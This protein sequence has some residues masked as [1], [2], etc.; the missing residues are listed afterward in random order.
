MEFEVGIHLRCAAVTSE[1][2]SDYVQPPPGNRSLRA[3]LCF[4]LPFSYTCS[5][6]EESSGGEGGREGR[7]LPGIFL[8]SGC[9][10][11]ITAEENG[12]DIEGGSDVSWAPG[13]QSVRLGAARR[14][15]C[16]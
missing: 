8:L 4:R 10:R 3:M 5:R 14:F 2:D 13:R 15:C 12:R 16:K 7:A 1:L 6:W 11:I 9:S